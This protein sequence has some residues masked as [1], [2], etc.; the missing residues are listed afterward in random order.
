MN[1]NCDNYNYCNYYN[2]CFNLMCT[3]NKLELHFIFSEV[4]FFF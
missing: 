1:N 4:V 2:N 3:E